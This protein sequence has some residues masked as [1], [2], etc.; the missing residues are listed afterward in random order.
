MQ[1]LLRKL[2]VFFRQLL[3]AVIHVLTSFFFV[4]YYLVQTVLDKR[5]EAVH[6]GKLVAQIDQILFVCLLG[7][8]HVFH[9]KSGLYVLSM[10][11]LTSN[12]DMY[13]SEPVSMSASPLSLL[14]P[15]AN[16]LLV[17]APP[18]LPVD[19]SLL[20]ESIESSC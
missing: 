10:P 7:V 15:T 18:L 13:T 12:S 20:A 19:C 6:L 4:L 9:I 14:C 3:S 5:H 11:K 8:V 17:L 2:N 1:E 16:R